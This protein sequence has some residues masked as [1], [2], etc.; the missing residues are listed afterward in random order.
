MH[1]YLNVEFIYQQAE[2]QPNRALKYI[3]V[4][5]FKSLPSALQT[6]LHDAAAQLDIEQTASVIEQ[7]K[8]IDDTVA[9]NLQQYLEQMD[10][11]AILDLCE[12]HELKTSD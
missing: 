5:N 2:S 7:I 3:Q 1:Q 10:F 11:Q 6:Q 12:K 4:E 9:F 8:A